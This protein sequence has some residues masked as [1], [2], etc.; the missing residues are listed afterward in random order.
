MLS[1]FGDSGFRFRRSQLFFLF[2]GACFHCLLLQPLAYGRAQRAT[3]RYS[4]VTTV[5]GFA[6]GTWDS[7]FAPFSMASRLD[8]RARE[9]AVTRGVYTGVFE[10]SL[11]LD[12][13]TR[14]PWNFLA[15]LSAELL[16]VSL[17]L[18]IPLLFSDALT[19][20]SLE[21]YRGGTSAFA[22]AVAHPATRDG[23]ANQTPSL[24]QP[25]AIPLES[26]ANAISPTATSADFTADAPPALGPATG[27]GG[28]TNTLG[29]FIP[30]VVATPPPPSANRGSAP[31][32]VRARQSE[33]GCSNGDA[34]AESDS[35]VSAAGTVGPH[36]RR[37]TADW[38]HR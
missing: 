27:Y 6:T 24:A 12:Q 1:R 21:R 14:R 15:S 18:L 29:T 17:A 36:L 11:L 38:H 4:W 19:H 7:F 22:A 28:S 3:I 13:G 5:F 31:A 16:V 23:V 9:L 34:G 25:R 35:R 37:R 32:A 33:R 20:G 2:H 8:I 30:N 26:L 10:Q